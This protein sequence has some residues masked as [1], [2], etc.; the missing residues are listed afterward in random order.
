MTDQKPIDWADYG[1]YTAPH[2]PA[3]WVH[4]LTVNDGIEYEWS[5]LEAFYSPTARRYFWY[6]DSGCSCNWWGDTLTSEAD[7]E[8]GSKADLERAIRTFAGR[9]SLNTGDFLTALDDLRRFKAPEVGD[10]D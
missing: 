5:T 10:H 3:D 9:G 8:N 1:V 4:V 7:F 2:M 6:G